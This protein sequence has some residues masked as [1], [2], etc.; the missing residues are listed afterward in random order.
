MPEKDCWNNV[1][2][3]QWKDD[4]ESAETIV[5]RSKSV[6]Q[7]MKKTHNRQLKV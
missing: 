2:S 6:V 4:S 1:S 3:S 7:Q 5:I